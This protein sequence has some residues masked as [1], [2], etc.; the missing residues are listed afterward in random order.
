MAD[1]QS[2]TG[3]Q[4]NLPDVVAGEEL[5]AS[6]ADRD[7]VVEVLRVAAGDGRLSAEELDDRLERA[8]TARTYTELA[9]LTTDLP[10][11]AGSVV[12]PPGAGAVN[13]TAKDLMRIHVNG[14]SVN[15][16]GR[17]VVP[18]ELDVKVKGGA[19]TLDFTEAVITQ[20][21]L[22]IIAEVRGGAFRLI[23]RPGI[24]VEAGDIS[25]HG[26][27]VTLPEPPGPGDPVQLRIEIAGSVHGA[28]ITAG[29]PSPPRPP[30]RSFWQWLR[31]APRRRAI[32]A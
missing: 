32:A 8:L 7:Q 3:G 4:S 15:R 28:A 26:G 21:V 5:R 29:P 20:P 9:A 31:R 1:P 23:T 27:S 14:S 12:V 24:V 17:W 22:R 18:K 13:A 6:H 10:A 11:T 25:A 16:D 19:V 30:R 2:S